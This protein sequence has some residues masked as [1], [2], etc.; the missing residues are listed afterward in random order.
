MA[1]PSKLPDWDTTEVNSTEPDTTHKEQGW[2]A[3]GGIPEKPPFQTFNYW[4]NLAWKWI[5]EFNKQGIVGWDGTTVYDIDDI[6]KGSDSLLYRS[7]TD[8][9]QNND[10]VGD[11]INWKGLLIETLKTTN[12]SQI[13]I[14]NLELGQ[15]IIIDSWSFVST[16][17]TINTNT[18]HNLNVGDTVY[19]AG[20]V[21]TT[22]EP[23]G[24]FII[25]SVI[26]DDTFTYIAS[27]TPT[28]SPT[29]SN[30][31]FTSGLLNTKSNVKIVD[32]GTVTI[33]TR[34]VIDNPFGDVYVNCV[35][36]IEI[37]GVWAETGWYLEG[38]SARGTNGGFVKGTGLVVQTGANFLNGGASGSGGLHGLVGSEQTSAPCRII[39]TY[40]GEATNA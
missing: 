40:T 26:D 20:L 36:E 32:F 17:I 14:G 5:K 22:N 31:L 18:D 27:A 7:L 2:L 29:V 37:G 21:A 39:V 28:G 4:M 11:I 1:K 3:P 8:T 13:K 15:S 9:N 24:T 19:I 38:G 6:T 30:A 12:E 33:D 34:Y 23:N 35:T 16:T 10:P 25:A